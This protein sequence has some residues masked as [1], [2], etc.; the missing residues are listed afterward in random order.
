MSYSKVKV[1]K[2]YLVFRHYT[3]KLFSVRFN[4][5]VIKP[6]RGLNNMFYT[7]TKC[8]GGHPILHRG[9][10]LNSKILAGKCKKKKKITGASSF[11]TGEL[12][13]NYP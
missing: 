6:F 7:L 10:K 9:L 12:S 8:T 5:P 1:S 13:K 11:F 2:I 4:Y 3:R